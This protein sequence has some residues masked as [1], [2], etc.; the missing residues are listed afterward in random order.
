MN[1]IILLKCCNQ[2]F[3]VQYLKRGLGNNAIIFWSPENKLLYERHHDA[4]LNNLAKEML[5]WKNQSLDGV[6]PAVK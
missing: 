2:P 4:C 1:H 3:E 5:K 6:L